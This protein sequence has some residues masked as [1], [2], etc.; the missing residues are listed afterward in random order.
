MIQLHVTFGLLSWSVDPTVLAGI[1]ALAAAY[2][3]LLR[4][5]GASLETW[6]PMSRVY[7]AAGLAVLLLALESLS[8]PPDRGQP[9]VQRRARYLAPP[10]PVPGHPDQ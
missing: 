2:A 5:R 10:F 8:G 3:W 9:G 6:S 4:H 1:A 7:F